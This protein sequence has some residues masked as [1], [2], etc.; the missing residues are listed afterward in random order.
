MNARLKKLSM[1]GS[2][3]TRAARRSARRTGRRAAAH[4]HRGHLLALH[5]ELPLQAGRQGGHS[6]PHCFSIFLTSLYL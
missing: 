3:T 1:A 5:E 6:V 4:G 2:V